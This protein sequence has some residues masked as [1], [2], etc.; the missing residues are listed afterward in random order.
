VKALLPLMLMLTGSAQ[1]HHPRTYLLSIV[2]IPLKPGERVQGFSIATWGVRFGAV[3]RIPYGWR[4]KAGN[5]ATPDGTLE[6][7]GSQG[8]TWFDR[9]SPKELRNFVLVTLYDAV[10]P[11]DIRENNGVIPATF[12][13]DATI[14]AEEGEPKVR[15]TSRNIRL[16]PARRCP[17]MD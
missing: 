14:S 16:V 15:L 1:V 10:Q 2:G 8:I 11:S 5:A 17:S 7:Q 3:C 9:S 13:G 4:I 6:G 12:K